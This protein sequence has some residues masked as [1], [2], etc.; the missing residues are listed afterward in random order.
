M[1]KVAKFKVI[2]E[3]ELG[4]SKQGCFK[5]GFHKVVAQGQFLGQ[6]IVHKA[7][8]FVVIP[9]ILDV[10]LSF[11]YLHKCVLGL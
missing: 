8:I 1:V 7:K 10:S 5:N 3:G 9:E 2:N 4:I 6:G 11:V